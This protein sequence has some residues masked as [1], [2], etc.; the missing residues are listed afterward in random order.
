MIDNKC[1]VNLMNW[2][3]YG[4][5]NLHVNEND[6]IEGWEMDMETYSNIAKDKHKKN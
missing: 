4:A 2:G 3:R 5:S 6:I 1:S